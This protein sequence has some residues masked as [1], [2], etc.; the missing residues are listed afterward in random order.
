MTEIEH[1]WCPCFLFDSSEDDAGICECGHMLD[2][3]ESAPG[4]HPGA[5]TIELED[6]R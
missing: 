2:E 3:H 1:L 6:H 5:C 4:G